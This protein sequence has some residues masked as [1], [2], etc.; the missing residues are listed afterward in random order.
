[1][2][3][4]TSAFSEVVTGLGYPEGPVPLSD[5]GFLCVDIK[6][7]ALLRYRPAAEPGCFTADPPI[8]LRDPA[9]RL[10]SGPNGAAVGPDGHVYVCNDGGKSF[11]PLPLQYSGKPYTLNVTTDSAADYAGGYIQRVNLETR[12]VEVWCAPDSVG[13]PVA[14]CSGTLIE[15]QPLSSPD[16]LIFD[17]TGGFWFTDWGNSKG[18][19]REVTGVYYVAAGTRTPI[20]KIAMRTAPNGIAL[21]PAGDRLYVAETYARTI[22]YWELSAP[23]ELKCNPITLDGAYLLSGDIPGSGLLDSMSL[24]EQGNVYVA[25][26]L[27]QG[28]DPLVN[29]GIT[30]ISP[31]GKL[32]EFIAVDCG[33]PEPLPSNLCFGGADRKTAFITCGGTGRV[34]SC[35]MQNA[36]LPAAFHR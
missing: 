26:L 7:A 36:G 4:R 27:P 13:Q 24:D 2:S 35:R 11:L 17:S 31:E 32:L 19:S 16:D 21:S 18:R 22:V 25:T 9:G 29:G 34:L 8:D 3:M 14:G 6:N 15:R 28:F 20:E 5:G 30:V 33:M 23:G 10:G 1:M 12:E